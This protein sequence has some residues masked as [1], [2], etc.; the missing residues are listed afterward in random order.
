[1]KLYARTLLFFLGVIVF[2]ALLTAGLILG[3]VS[4]DNLAD[5]RV[6]L[7]EESARVYSAYGSWVRVLWKSAVRIESDPLMTVLSTDA[8]DLS[9][10]IRL[11]EELSDRL[12]DTGIDAFVIR[13]TEPPWFHYEIMIDTNPR[14]YDFS[15][16]ESDR[17]HP[18]VSLRMIDNETYLTSTLKF[19]TG[20]ELYLLKRINQDFYEHLTESERA[21][22]LV[23]NDNA[24]ILE[25]AGNQESL[26]EL[27][28]TS[29]D[30]PPYQ[31]HFDRDLGMGHYNF[32]FQNLGTFGGDSPGELLYLAV[33]LSDAPYR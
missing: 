23:T 21:L 6:E 7:R 5:A 30:S 11:R 28:E 15:R 18:Y 22:V 27:L 1:M 4:R 19:N 32:S 8:A 17:N 20:T 29:G 31:E 33:F 13:S 26:M 24:A 10:Q 16:L 9:G 2:Q 14:I 12:Q 25:V 3:L